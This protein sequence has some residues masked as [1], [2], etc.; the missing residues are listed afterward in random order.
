MQPILIMTSK[1]ELRMQK[2]LKYTFNCSSTSPTPTVTWKRKSG[3]SR[4]DALSPNMKMKSHGQE[5][6]INKAVYDD[7]GDY[8]C[9]ASNV[10]AG[11]AVRETFT[12]VVECKYTCTA[13][14]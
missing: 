8:E 14:P 13:K 4:G 1:I 6:Y 2:Y 3:G 5:L 11:P 9:I 12:L 10:E 7:A